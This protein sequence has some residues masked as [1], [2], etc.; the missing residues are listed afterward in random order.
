M[1]LTNRAF[2]ILVAAWLAVANSLLADELAD[3][4]RLP[5]SQIDE[6]DRGHWAYLTVRRP[7]VPNVK[8]KAWPRTP[9]D[10]FVLAKLEAQAWQPN[11]VADSAALLRRIYLDLIGLPPTISEQERFG[12]APSAERL[13]EEADRLLRRPGYGERWSRHWLDLVRYADSNGYERDAEK[14]HV[15]RYR[16]YVIDALNSDKPYDRFVMEQLAGDELAAI[17][18]ETVIATG[19]YRLGSWDDEPADSAQD[20]HDQLDDIIRTTSQVFLGL[21]LGCARCHDH[22]FDTLTMHDY[23]RMSA[24]VAPMQRPQSGRSDQDAP[25]GSAEQLAIVAERDRRIEEFRSQQKWIRASYLGEFLTSGKSELADNVLSAFKNVESERSDAEKKL[26]ADHQGQLDQE[27]ASHLPSRMKDLT[28]RA[29]R[30]IKQLRDQVADLPRGY[31]LIEPEK[32]PSKSFLL[33][34]GQAAKPGQEVQPGLPAVLLRQQPRFE[35]RGRTSRRRIAMATWI[36]SPDNPL[37]ARVIVNRVWQYHFGEGIVRTPS[38]F[39]VMGDTPTHPELLDWLAHWF[40]HDAN[41]SLKKLHRL[42]VR[43]NSYRMSKSVNLQYVKEDPENHLLWRFPYRRLQIEAI[44]DSVLA[45]SGKLNRTM[46]GPGVKL[47]IPRVVVEG[48][49]DRDKVWQP[50]SP[51]EQARR[52]VYAFVKRSLMVPLLEV[53]DLCDTTRSTE[54]RNITSVPPQALTLFNGKFVNEQARHLAERV[55]AEAGDHPGAQV[56]RAWR[57]ALCRSPKGT[58]QLAMAEFLNAEQARLLGEAE[59]GTEM[60]VEEA[61]RRALIQVCRVIFNLNEFAYPN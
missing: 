43:S 9:I 13:D 8:N 4:V 53:L 40:V 52:T 25:A 30:H 21:S 27:L 10:N 58:E 29:E 57:I 35:T 42:I 47:H 55:I 59:D 5:E 61:H 22:K 12:A 14:P 41:W 28:E 15:W 24:I 7:P 60:S 23:Y 37:T 54:Q 2:W 32:K 39:G 19:F 48:H 44:R 33:L 6:S 36:A 49:A 1:F 11:P 17:S 31:F 38:D 18:T 20:R 46:Y 45:A 3:E 50:S 16:D 51:E 34:R 56:E 26:V